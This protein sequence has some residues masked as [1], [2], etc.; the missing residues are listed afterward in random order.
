MLRRSLRSSLFITT[1]KKC[2]FNIL[3]VI[4]CLW[5][6]VGFMCWLILLNNN[7]VSSAKAGLTFLTTGNSGCG[8]SCQILRVHGP[9]PYAGF[10]TLI[11]LYPINFLLYAEK[12]N[13]YL[14]IDYMPSFNDKYYDPA[15]GNNMWEYWMEPM[16]PPLDCNFW[17]S[18]IEVLTKEQIFPGIHYRFKEGVRAWYYGDIERERFKGKYEIYDEQWYYQ[19]RVKA[20]NIVTK[21]SFQNKIK[22]HIMHEIDIFFNEHLRG[23]KHILGV[24]MRGTDKAAHRR[25]ILP[26]EY[27][28][29]ITNFIDF[30]GTQHTMVFVATDDLLY[31]EM[32]FHNLQTPYKDKIVMQSNITRGTKG[33]AIFDLKD[34]SKYEIGKQVLTDIILL[35]RCTWLVHSASAVSEAAI[36]NNIHLHNHSVHL[37]YTKN[38]Q[39]PFWFKS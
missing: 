37:E 23:Y 22:S 13:M 6:V 19:N 7:D 32:L 15:H 31:V 39:T 34:I 18:K 17:I 1:P 5:I 27:I 29:Y 28:P 24:H 9:D 2:S 33:S 8:H 11:F 25:A 4:I 26:D 38:R 35:S 30:F 20:S 21:Y 14:W 3:V 12:H 10:G 36:Y 16:I